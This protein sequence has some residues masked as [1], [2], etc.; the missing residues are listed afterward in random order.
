MIRAF[1]PDVKI[2]LNMR[3]EWLT[4]LDRAMIERR[5][6]QV[7]S[8]IGCSEYITEKIRRHFPQ[9]AGRCQTVH[10]GRDVNCLVPADSRG[11]TMDGGIKR[12]LYVGRI[13]PEK[14]VH[15]LLEAFQE[16]VRR[17]PQVELELVGLR[18]QLPYKYLIAL[19]DNPRVLALASFYPE[20]YFSHLNRLSS[21]V[22]GRVS[23][24]GAVPHLELVSYYQRT[25]IFVF[26]SV[27]DEPF[28]NPPVEAQLAAVPVVATRVGGIVETVKDGKTGLLVEPGD[29]AALAEAIVCLLKDED[30]RR[31]MGK[32]GRERAVELFSY[33]RLVENLLCR[34][35][36]I[37]G[38]NE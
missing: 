21:S 31:S 24:V 8:V 35:K 22:A 7:D 27:W 20:N 29:P 33:E 26:P 11:Q 32:A 36:E 19:S 13:S 2:V 4:Q 15:V 5:L 3:C 38:V 28:G 10:N 9:F 18:S 17:C 16:V 34:Y 30:L 6:G 25:D 37:C 12:L 14:G 1:N 23:F